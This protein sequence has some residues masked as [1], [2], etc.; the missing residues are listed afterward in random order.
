MATRAFTPQLTAPATNNKYW[1]HKSKGGLNE[2]ILINKKTGS[3][4]PNCVAWAW[5]R[6]YSAWGVRPKLSR[7]NAEDWYSYKDGYGRGKTPKLGAIICWRKGKVGYSADGAGHVAF[8]EKINEDGS[9]VVSNSNYSG[10]RFFTRTLTK[11]S[12]YYIGTGLTF[13]GFIYPPVVLVQ[14]PP[15]SSI[16]LTNADYPVSI[17]Q[18]NYFTITGKITS[19]L[20]LVRV[21]VAILDT[22]GGAVYKYTAKP[23]TKTFDVHKADQSMMFRKLKKGKYTYKI[24]AWDNNGGHTVLSKKFVVK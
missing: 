10:T 1:I 3:C 13:Q 6:A 7:G 9:I 19:A 23:K 16:K 14:T 8:V 15:K 2:C 18:G 20:A 17:K 21:D 11:A 24:T 22:K 5:G 4:L 12:K